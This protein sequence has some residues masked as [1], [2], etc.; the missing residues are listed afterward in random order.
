MWLKNI[1]VYY[2]IIKTYWIYMVNENIIRFL[3]TWPARIIRV[4][5][6]LKASNGEGFEW[7]A[8]IFGVAIYMNNI[9]N[10]YWILMIFSSF[11]SAFQALSN[12]VKFIENW[13]TL[14]LIATSKVLARHSM[15]CG[16]SDLIFQRMRMSLVCDS[17]WDLDT[18]WPDFAICNRHLLYSRKVLPKSKRFILH[19][20]RCDRP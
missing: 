13:W 12:D 8:N 17:V 14:I 19:T 3:Q 15:P 20:M 6:N 4:S 16:H 1:L 5:F 7:Q 18:S 9:L 10:M 11:W 2:F